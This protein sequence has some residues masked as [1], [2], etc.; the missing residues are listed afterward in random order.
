VATIGHDFRTRKQSRFSAHSPHPVP[1][2][3]FSN[4]TAK[5]HTA[6]DRID[7]TEPHC[8]WSTSCGES[9]KCQIFFFLRDTIG[10]FPLLSTQ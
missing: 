5:A 4:L 8:C 9:W 1:P 2:T 7:N 3:E 10:P 6:L